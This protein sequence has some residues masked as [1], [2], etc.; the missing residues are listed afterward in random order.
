MI[1]HR[2]EGRNWNSE[3]GMGK[4]ENINQSYT[5][6]LIPSNLDPILYALSPMP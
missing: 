2:A 5:L 4:S 1:K 3:G 6:Y